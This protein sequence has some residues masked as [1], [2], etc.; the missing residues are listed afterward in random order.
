MGSDDANEGPR[1]GECWEHRWVLEGASMSPEGAQ[2]N[3]VCRRCGAIMV[4]PSPDADE[5]RRP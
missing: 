5:H 2:M 1:P 3:Y 4:D